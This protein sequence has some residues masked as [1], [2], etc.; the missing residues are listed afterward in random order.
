MLAS[1][2]MCFLIAYERYVS[3]VKTA[4][5]IAEALGVIYESVRIPE[6]TLVCGTVGV[7]LLVSGVLCYREY[8]KQLHLES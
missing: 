3:A 1:A 2:A 5:Q 6:V 4:E 8:R 7:A